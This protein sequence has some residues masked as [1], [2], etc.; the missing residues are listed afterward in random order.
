MLRSHRTMRSNLNMG[1]VIERHPSKASDT[2]GALVRELKLNSLDQESGALLHAFIRQIPEDVTLF[3][4]G[5][6]LEV[7][8]DQC[9]YFVSL[10]NDI[11]FV[12]KEHARIHVVDLITHSN[13]VMHYHYLGCL[14]SDG[15]CAVYQASRFISEMYFIDLDYPLPRS[16]F[17]N[18]VTT[19]FFKS[20]AAVAKSYKQGSVCELNINDRYYQ[21]HI[22]YRGVMHVRP[23]KHCSNDIRVEFLDKQIGVGVYGAVYKLPTHRFI[24]GSL[25]AAKHARIT[26]IIKPIVCS[27]ARVEPEAHFIR[28]VKREQ[29]YAAIFGLKPKPV[30]F[31]ESNQ[32]AYLTQREVPGKTLQ[33]FLS[34]NPHPI[35]ADLAYRI[36]IACL[37]VLATLHQQGVLHGDPHMANIMLEFK[38][39][40][41]VHA[42]WVDAG[43]AS[44]VENPSPYKPNALLFCPESAPSMKDMP[45]Y[46]A[47][48]SRA[49]E[50]YALGVVLAGL[51]GFDYNNNHEDKKNRYCL[52]GSPSRVEG[53]SALEV[54][55]LKLLHE[56]L[57]ERNPARRY[58]AGRAAMQLHGYFKCRARS[59]LLNRSSSPERPG[60]K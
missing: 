33:S 4:K 58:T 49:A 30:L 9:V 55:D 24:A 52:K 41:S 50:V 39:D 59:S 44:R 32:V 16:P 35:K 29:E 18:E 28:R 56:G 31:E 25:Q 36:S 45:G 5:K 7:T 10:D 57:L 17:F 37:E 3:P 27:D 13:D 34:E 23:S 26:K 19:H 8:V 11:L 12:S 51:W 47:L 1:V 48:N 22:K 42:Q 43:S 46:V 6:V 38:S 15:R 53:L 40:E 60:L 21:L 54:K 14:V 2:E 20:H